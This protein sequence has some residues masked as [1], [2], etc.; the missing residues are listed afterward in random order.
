MVATDGTNTT[1]AVTTTASGGTLV[2]S[3]SIS[4][5][6]VNNGTIT[7]ISRRRLALPE[8]RTIPN[9]FSSR[10]P[11]PRFNVTA[12]ASNLDAANAT[13][14]TPYTFQPSSLTTRS[15]IADS[16]FAGSTVQVVPSER[17]RRRP[18]PSVVSTEP[19]GVP[20]GSG[21]ASTISW[22]TYQITP[23]RRGNWSSAP[24]GTYQ[25]V[26]GGSPVTDLDSNTAPTGT[27]GTFL[28]NAQSVLL[29]NIQ[30]TV[31]QSGDLRRSTDHAVGHGRRLRQPCDF[32]SDLRPGDGTQWQALPDGLWRRQ[33]RG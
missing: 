32:Q 4:A 17:A 20:D 15:L 12:L 25:V 7:Y 10:G 28:V 13:A 3:C 8:A 11:R 1:A 23:P 31:N 24:A 9:P 26:L 19:L 5:S 6:F 14:L 18:P 16:S 33:H 30:F 27:V 21:N 22:Y 2:E 29:Q